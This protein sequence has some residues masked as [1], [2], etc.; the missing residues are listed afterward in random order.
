MGEGKRYNQAIWVI[1]KADIINR[2][3]FWCLS[4]AEEGEKISETGSEFL[5]GEELEGGGAGH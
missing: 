2:G 5:M 1:Y 4:L 3:S